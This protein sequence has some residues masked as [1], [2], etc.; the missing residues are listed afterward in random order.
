MKEALNVE[1]TQ[2]IQ[3]ERNLDSLQS[4]YKDVSI[5]KESKT[6][7]CSPDLTK[8][9][10]PYIEVDFLLVTPKSH[11]N[12]Y[13]VIKELQKLNPYLKWVSPDCVN[14]S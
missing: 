5:L 4:L 11:R 6:R 14:S 10:L 13:E 8:N 7:W 2:I 1:N 3:K 12:K 9:L